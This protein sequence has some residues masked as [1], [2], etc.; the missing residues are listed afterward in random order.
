MTCDRCKRP[1]NYEP[2]SGKIRLM[3]ASKEV[4]AFDLCAGCSESFN[5]RTE[6]W[7]NA[8]EPVETPQNLLEAALEAGKRSVHTAT[9]AGRLD[10]GFGS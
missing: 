10:K 2:G 6:Q 8:G 3:L 1:I 4:K 7:L 9:D 5:H